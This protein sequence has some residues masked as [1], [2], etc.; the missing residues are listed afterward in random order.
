MVK[1]RPTD[2]A[3]YN[4]GSVKKIKEQFKQFEGLDI[5]R[6]KGIQQ[7]LDNDED[8][9]LFSAGKKHEVIEKHTQRM[10]AQ[11]Q[12]ELEAQAK[13]IEEQYSS[14]REQSQNQ[15]KMILQLQNVMNS[16]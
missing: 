7:T 11:H 3:D 2:L 6:L 5:E 9:A 14:I 10:R 12:Q 1:E 15:Y 8:M 16:L 4:I 13:M